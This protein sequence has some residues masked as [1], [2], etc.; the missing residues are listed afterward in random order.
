M[1]ARREEVARDDDPNRNDPTCES[2]P[3]RSRVVVVEN[4]FTTS[5]NDRYYGYCF[6][7]I[8]FVK[9]KKKKKNFPS[10]ARKVQYKVRGKVETIISFLEIVFEAV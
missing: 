10:H 8:R 9:K 1:T 3:N 2:N 4:F 7:F 5:S 6:A